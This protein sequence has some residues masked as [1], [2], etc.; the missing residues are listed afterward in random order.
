MSMDQKREEQEKYTFIQE[1]VVPS[2]RKR[3]KKLLARIGTAVLTGTFFGAAAVASIC[4]AGPW[5]AER[6]GA[7][8]EQKEEVPSDTPQVTLP[9][10]QYADAEH[11]EEDGKDPALQQPEDET[12]STGTDA[13]EQTPEGSG[14]DPE[15]S[16]GEETIAPPELVIME[17][18]IQGDLEDFKNIYQ[19][20]AEMAAEVNKSIVKVASVTSGIDWFQNPYETEESTSGVIL[21]SDEE[22]LYI[23]TTYSLIDEASEIRVTFSQNISAVASFRDADPDTDLA[24]ITVAKKELPIRVAAEM[25]EAPLGESYSL[26]IGDPVIALGDPNGM[27]H[28]MLFGM[29]TSRDGSVYLPDNKLPLFYTDMQLAEDGR[30]YVINMNGKIVGIISQSLEQ[31]ELC[32][33]ISISRIRPLLEKLINQT[34]RAY[35]GVVGVDLSESLTQKLDVTGGIYVDEVLAG[36]PADVAGIRKGDVILQTDGNGVFTMLALNAYLQD[37]MPGDTAKLK[38]CRMVREEAITSTYDVTLGEKG[39]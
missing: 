33:V 5:I 30:G 39:K 37:K 36:S 10:D 6:I 2:R 34:P 27:Q 18:R 21:A 24:I 35:L 20:I 26:K 25:K 31:E 28:S 32:T 19:E 29:V 11:P 8:S 1:Q 16:E 4:L 17:Q 3:W 23:L 15:N 38:I 7:V 9:E 22:L 14:E 12:D 13:A